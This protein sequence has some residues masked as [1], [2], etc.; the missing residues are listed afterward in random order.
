MDREMRVLLAWK[1]V[2]SVFPAFDSHLVSVLVL[3]LMI[4]EV[5]PRSAL[6]G[7]SAAERRTQTVGFSV[8][9]LQ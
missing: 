3:A 8:V 9:E 4:C 6:L 7:T 2:V 5:C 1:A